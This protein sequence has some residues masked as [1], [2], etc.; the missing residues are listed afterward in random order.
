M[1]GSEIEGMVIGVA[2]IALVAWL[3]WLAATK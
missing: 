2:I 3:I 1:T